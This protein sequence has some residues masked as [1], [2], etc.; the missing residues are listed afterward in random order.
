MNRTTTWVVPLLALALAGCG[1]GDKGSAAAEEKPV[2]PRFVD[3][4]ELVS[5]NLDERLPT[6]GTEGETLFEDVDAAGAG[7]DFIHRWELTKRTVG[8]VD[9]IE[10]G[11]GVTIGD[12][13]SDGLPDVFL[14]RPVGGARLFRNLG[15]FRFEDITTAAGLASDAAELP[16]GSSFADIDNDGDLDLAV[17]YFGRATRLYINDGKGA[18]TDRAGALGMDYTGSG[19][20]IA[21]SDYDRDGDLDAFLAT[22]RYAVDLPDPQ[23][24][25]GAYVSR[26]MRREADGSVSFPPQVD[27][28]WGAINR[29]GKGPWIIRTGQRGRLFRNEGGKFSEVGEEAGLDDR[30]MT[31]SATWWDHNG[32]GWPDLYMANDFM[33]ADRLYENQR[34]GTFRDVASQVLPHVPWYSMGSDVGDINNDGLEDFIATDMAGS[35]HYKSKLAMGDMDKFAWFLESGTPRQYMRNAVYL[36]TGAGRKL[37]V[38]QQLGLDASDWTWSPKLGDLDCDGWL[39]IFITNGMS[40]DWFN[41]DLRRQIQLGGGN[42]PIAKLPVKRDINMALRNRGGLKF[43]DVGK[44]WGLAEANASF[45]AAL[46]DLDLDGDLDIIVNRFKEPVALYRNRAVGERIKVKLFGR[47]SNSHGVGATV[48]VRAGDITRTRT[49]TLA[50]GVLSTNEPA[51][52][53]GLGDTRRIDE[54]EVLW[55]SGHTQRFDHLDSGKTYE[56]TEPSGS[57][58]AIPVE[59]PVEPLYTRNT[60]FPELRHLEA[61]FDDFAEQPLLPNRMSRLGA[62]IAVGD[63]DGDGDEDAYVGNALGSAGS[64]WLRD[65]DTWSE[66]A[67]FPG[68]DSHE[69]MG[70]LFFDADGDGDSDLYVVSGGVEL[71]KGR[72]GYRDR[73]YLND[74]TGKFEI[75]AGNVLPE[76]ADSGSCVVAGDY[77]LDGDLDLFVGGRVVPGEY[78]SP[79]TS[80]L[81]RNDSGVAGV[82]FSDVTTEVAAA[83]HRA[84]MVTAA[85]WSDVDADGDPDL[86]VTYEWG[87]VRLFLNAGG[88]F[89]DA[90]TESGVGDLLGWWNGIAGGDVDAD[91]DIDYAVSNFGLNTKYHPTPKKPAVLYYGD[92]S[93]DGLNRIV[94]A[95][96]TS[97]GTLPVRGFSCSSAAISGI[98][99]K[100]GYK[101]PFHNFATKMLEEIYPEEKLA[102]AQ[103]FEANELRSGVL[104]ND[105]SGKFEFRPL[106]D[107]AQVAPGFGLGF[108]DAD[109]D[110]FLDLYLVQNFFAPQPETGRMHGGVSLMMSGRGTGEFDPVWPEQSGLVVSGDG[111]GFAQLADGGFLISQNDGATLKFDP[112]DQGC[113]LRLVGKPGNPSAVGARV[114]CSFRGDHVGAFE[115]YAGSGYLSASSASIPVPLELPGTIDVSVRW[116]DGSESQHQI[117]APTGGGIRQPGQS[118]PIRRNK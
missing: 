8:I 7:M 26:L 47:I 37:E 106:P 11:G 102:D 27:G 80:R 99:K 66:G 17:C 68:S 113:V 92:F 46:A 43:E 59:D 115:V 84:G 19:I 98:S 87:P 15:G 111:K 35:T 81:L 65:G 55:P 40:A 1:P 5:V 33:G 96:K 77:D 103:R 62:G 85:L 39:D 53:F 41:S 114:S 63:V 108:C 93:G 18:F 61:A 6:G 118:D 95:K 107:L 48:K 101:T 10:A 72:A 4:V 64:L 44:R 74:G 34:D 109:G 28:L 83:A 14:T 78:P 3:R 82:R 67:T 32:D 89:K 45:G 69:D 117:T 110:S 104:L 112:R 24:D 56:I 42:T 73:L 54:I 76:L 70:S 86:L 90:T 75:A 116:P 91:G 38:A 60:M 2:S 52:Y 94:E 25:Q 79:P 29:P 31:L 20:M 100:M 12:I 13:D 30:G 88:Q 50:S 58:L 23:L 71:S 97:D 105:G 16:T 21:F 57:P 51:L 22:H 49:L 9:R 36:N